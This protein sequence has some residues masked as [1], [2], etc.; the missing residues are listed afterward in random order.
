VKLARRTR[1]TRKTRIMTKD[2]RKVLQAGSMQMTKMQA[3]TKVGETEE[4]VSVRQ[5]EA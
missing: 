1:K 3:E 5:M 2:D 4:D